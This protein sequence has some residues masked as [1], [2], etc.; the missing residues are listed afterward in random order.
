MAVGRAAMRVATRVAM[1]TALCALAVACG[2]SDEEITL[3][4]DSIIAA[5]KTQGIYERNNLPQ[6]NPPTSEQLKGYYDVVGGAY[7][8]IVNEA[9]ENR[10]GSEFEIRRGDNIE[11]M[12]D[13]R[14]FSRGNFENYTTFYTNIA[15]RIAE[16]TGNNPAFDGRFWPTDPL[17]IKV[18]EDPGILKSLQE[19]LISC[20]AGDG[21]PSNDKEEDGIASDQIR[22]YLTSDIAFGN[23]TV[24]NVPAGSTIVF[25]I[26]EIEIIR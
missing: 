13:A 21:D 20:R 25:E 26:T 22:V 4:R 8:W 15:S 9:R 3:A 16:L 1:L 19:A 7:R 18:G 5:L 23:K 12:F 17:K 10:G 11:F 14:I 2:K 6:D 24:Y